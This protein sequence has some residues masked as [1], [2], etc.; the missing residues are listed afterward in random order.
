[1]ALAF[2][3]ATAGCGRSGDDPT[4]R[5]EVPTTEATTTSTTARPTTTTAPA[6]KETFKGSGNPDQVDEAADV[7]GD[8]RDDAVSSFRAG[9][10]EGGRRFVLDVALAAGGGASVD[11]AAEE[12]A[13]VALLGGAVVERRDDREL[14]WVRVGA[15]ASTVILGL[16]WFD[17]C[18]LAPVRRPDGEPVE[19][20]IGGTVGSVSGAECGSV[21]DPEADVLVYEGR[22][23][24]GEEYEVTV[25]ELRYANGVLSPSP[26]A[27]P[28]TSTTDDVSR[29]ARFR[30]DDLT[31]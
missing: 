13:S 14:L 20:P 30:C 22:H 12:D 28:A 23:V 9:G 15:G 3:L 2:L 31:L 25:T 19:L 26:G 11:I 24:G 4:L 8:G 6:C 29:A 10:E 7:D 21:A 27:E 17:D 18:E 1:V 5:G 16:Y